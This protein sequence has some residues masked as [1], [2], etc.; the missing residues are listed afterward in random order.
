MAILT[1]TANTDFEGQT[2]NNIDDVAFTGAFNADF[3]ASQ[4]GPGHVSN[5]LLVTGNGQNPA[6][7]IN[8]YNIAGTFSAAIWSYSGIGPLSTLGLHG[9]A[10]SPNGGAGGAASS[11]AGGGVGGSAGSASGGAPMLEAGAGGGSAPRASD[12]SSPR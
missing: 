12:A 3:S 9:G 10:G 8:V 5:A 7:N 11:I 2:L 1:V 4:F 6:I